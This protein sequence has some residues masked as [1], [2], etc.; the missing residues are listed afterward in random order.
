[1]NRDVQI[2]LANVQAMMD[3]CEIKIDT[4]KDTRTTSVTIYPDKLDIVEETAKIYKARSNRFGK[5]VGKIE[6]IIED[7][8]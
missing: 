5:L 7:A 1:M 8:S 3:K 4:N 2:E 6:S